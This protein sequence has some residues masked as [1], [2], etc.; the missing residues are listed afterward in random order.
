MGYDEALTPGSAQ[1]CASCQSKGETTHKDGLGLNLHTL[2]SLKHWLTGMDI[3]TLPLPKLTS[4]TKLV[5]ISVTHHL[6]KKS[7]NQLSQSKGETT[8]KDGLGLNLHALPSL[9]H[10]LA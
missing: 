10:T 3:Q 8:H 9:E 1:A 7:G 6:N 5:G 4:Q 2:T